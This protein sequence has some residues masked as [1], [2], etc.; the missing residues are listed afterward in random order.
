METRSDW[1]V[2]AAKD[3]DTPIVRS[4]NKVEIV[5]ANELGIL[6]EHKP[7]KVESAFTILQ[8]LC[9]Q[10]LDRIVVPMIDKEGYAYLVPKNCG[11]HA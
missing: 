1:L 11:D 7:R 6:Q 9:I 3:Q 5:T 2:D 8:L 10:N 4:K